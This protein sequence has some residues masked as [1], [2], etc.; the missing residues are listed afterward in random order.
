MVQPVQIF[1]VVLAVAL[2]V[3][4]TLML[5]FT[6]LGKAIRAVA[7]NR[8]AAQLLGVNMGRTVAITFFLASALGALSGILYS[9]NLQDVASLIWATRSSCVGWQ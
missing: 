5:R 6:R 8:L 9:L 7:A 3:G 2:M 1:I 4:L